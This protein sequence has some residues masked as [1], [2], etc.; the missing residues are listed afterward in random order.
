VVKARRDGRMMYYSL[1]DHH[2][3]SLLAEGFRHVEE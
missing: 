3:V 1:D 2:I